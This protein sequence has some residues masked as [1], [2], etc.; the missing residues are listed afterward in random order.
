MRHAI[1][2]LV[3]VLAASFVLPSNVLAQPQAYDVVVDSASEPTGLPHNSFPYIRWNYAADGGA[4]NGSMLWANDN[5]S[6]MHLWGAG[7]GLGLAVVQQSN[8]RQIAWSIDQGAGGS[9]IINT[10]YDTGDNPGVRYHTYVLASTGTLAAGFH[11]LEVTTNN[12]LGG[13]E[14][15]ILDALYVY[16][17]L[18]TKRY[19]NE[20]WW[21]NGGPGTWAAYD[22]GASADIYASAASICYSLGSNV[23]CTYRFNGSAVLL[24]YQPRS[25]WDVTLTWDVDSGSSSGSISAPYPLDGGSTNFRTPVILDNSLSYGMHDLVLSDLG[26]GTGWQ[27]RLLDAIE[28]IDDAPPKTRYEIAKGNTNNKIGFIHW[29]NWYEETGQPGAS[30]GDRVY[31]FDYTTQGATQSVTFLCYGTGVDLGIYRYGNGE[32][33]GWDVDDG[34]YTGMYDS[35]W[36]LGV[37]DYPMLPLTGPITLTPGFHKVTVTNMD[38]SG[39]AI[40][41]LDYLDVYNDDWSSV[42]EV[43][44]TA[45]EI[46]YNGS[47]NTAD[48]DGACSGGSR[49]T[50][51]DNTTPASMRLDFEGTAVAVLGW[52]QSICTS[53]NWSIDGGAG[54][55]GTV[56]QYDAVDASVRVVDFIVNGLADTV[57]T[58]TITHGGA[59]GAIEIDLIAV[60]GTPLAVKDWQQY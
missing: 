52:R 13:G 36:W 54:G 20:Y 38:Q 60:K 19:E 4:Y 5:S 8:T 30:N 2:V 9:G 6:A 18:P 33:V 21:Y 45:T 14:T 53:Y 46:I 12:S 32:Y 42:T 41:V 3:L 17:P 58:L 57:H 34:S 44:N 51:T 49:A 25:D 26:D 40:T 24:V 11:I 47:W 15:I 39:A 50:T 10:N 56:D 43:E 35:W 29:N 59:A 28:V 16:G 55:S 7:T 48:P 23:W 27:L 22:Q 31:A 37:G 1:G